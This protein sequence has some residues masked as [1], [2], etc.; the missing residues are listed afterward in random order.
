VAAPHHDLTI[1]LN[2]SFWL[3]LATALVGLGV[4]STAMAGKDQPWAEIRVE[5]VADDDLGEYDVMLVSINGAIDID[6]ATLYK[7][8]PG[9]QRLKVASLKRGKYGELPTLPFTLEMKPCVR[10]ALVANYAPSGAV[11]AW[12]V[13][14]K[15]ESPIKACVKKYGGGALATADAAP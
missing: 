8:P 12:S 5:G 2:R 4:T 13:A 10:Y 9:A 7:L 6:T 15:D 11:R 14:V 3:L 1:M